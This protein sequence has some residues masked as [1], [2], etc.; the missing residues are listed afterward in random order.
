M[1]KYQF[2][3]VI[4]RDEDGVFIATCP[5]LQGCYTQGDTYAEAMENI[6]DAI[7][8]HVG[9]RQEL[10]ETIPTEFALD[11]IEISA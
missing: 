6:R 10:G 11:K 1:T 8:L 4:E 5:L 2:T 9:A 7:Q 3:V